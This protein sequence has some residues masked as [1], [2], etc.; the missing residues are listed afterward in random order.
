M[1]RWKTVERRGAKATQSEGEREREGERKRD[2]SRNIAPRLL[3]AFSD[4]KSNPDFA[5]SYFTPSF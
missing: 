2:R 5:T 1:N 4:F 3:Y